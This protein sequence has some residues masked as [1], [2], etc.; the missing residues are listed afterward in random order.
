MGRVWLARLHLFRS[1]GVL[2][3][4]AAAA[5]MFTGTAAFAD[6]IVITGG[7][8]WLPA[9]WTGLDPPFG[10]DLTGARTSLGGITFSQTGGSFVQ[11]GDPINLSN[12]L[13]V[14]ANPFR[15]GPFEQT[16]NGVTYSGV[17]LSGTL[18]FSATPGTVTSADSVGF[19]TPFTM[20]GSL[21]LFQG[22]ASN[23]FSPGSLLFTIPVEG[24]G[25]ASLGLVPRAG[26]MAGTSVSYAFADPAA[27]PTPEP[28]TLT[29]LGS[30]VLV[31]VDRARRKR[32]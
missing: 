15:T 12:T 10:W 17:F 25:T 18:N 31:M 4:L 26:M 7:G 9:V 6:P 19:D 21:S 16:V 28:A 3:S 13:T 14:S 2:V 20:D 11:P 24:R 22:D 8:V 32:R 30:G 29:L 27:S 1:R 5:V 23:P